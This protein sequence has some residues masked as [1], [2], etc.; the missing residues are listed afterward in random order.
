VGRLCVFDQLHHGLLRS[1]VAAVPQ[2]HLPES[3][4]AHAN[5]AVFST[6]IATILQP[7]GSHVACAGLR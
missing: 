4:K 1:G 7:L 5:T 6:A 3:V 2:A